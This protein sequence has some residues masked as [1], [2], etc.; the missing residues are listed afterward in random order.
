[1][2]LRQWPS[3]PDQPLAADIKKVS[4]QTQRNRGNGHR[5]DET[6]N[7]DKDIS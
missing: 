4:E 6:M 1:M 7:K 3:V 5:K 2:S